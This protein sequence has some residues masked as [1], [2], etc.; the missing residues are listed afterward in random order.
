MCR[1]GEVR[2]QSVTPPR[3]S[4]PPSEFRLGGRD[5]GTAEVEAV[6]IEGRLPRLDLEVDESGRA[7]TASYCMGGSGCSHHRT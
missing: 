6:L 5:D 1:S 4:S 7:E 2:R 3:V